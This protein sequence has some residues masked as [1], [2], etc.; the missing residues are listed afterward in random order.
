MAKCFGKE[1]K[2]LV[3]YCSWSSCRLWKAPPNFSPKSTQITLSIFLHPSLSCPMGWFCSCEAA[4]WN[5]S[6]LCNRCGVWCWSRSL[7]GL[8]LTEPLKSALWATKPPD[9]MEGVLGACT[10]L[11]EPQVG[12][13][14]WLTDCLL[15]G[16]LPKPPVSAHYNNLRF[17]Y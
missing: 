4:F 11:S 8:R 17:P 16:D 9:C 12:N 3:F 10:K 5:P 2:F 7:G 13:S 1:V 15:Q 6:K 14:R